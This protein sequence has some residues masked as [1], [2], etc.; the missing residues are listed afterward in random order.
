MI[1]SKGYKLE[2]REGTRWNEK[3][4]SWYLECRG[5]GEMTRI[6]NKDIASVLCYK[7]VSKSLS[8]LENPKPVVND[9]D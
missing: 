8:E 1:N 4:K 2:Y 6:G 5:C 3:G 7:C 9:N